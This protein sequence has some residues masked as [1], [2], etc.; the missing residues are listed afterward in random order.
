VYTNSIQSLFFALLY[1]LVGVLIFF[2]IDREEMEAHVAYGELPAAV[3]LNVIRCA[4]FLISCFF[5][6]P[7]LLGAAFLE[8]AA[9]VRRIRCQL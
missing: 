1:P 2:R 6:L 8:I 4:I 9:S 3:S 5:W 7:A